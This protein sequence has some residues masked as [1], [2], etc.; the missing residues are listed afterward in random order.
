MTYVLIEIVIRS[1]VYT[2]IDTVHQ[3][4]A[5]TN[6]AFITLKVKA[7]CFELVNYKLTLFYLN[8]N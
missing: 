5:Y 1:P 7:D 2:F 8:L 3:Y 4:V 6:K